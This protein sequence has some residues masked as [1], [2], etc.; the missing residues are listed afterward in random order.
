MAF[1]LHY[2][3]VTV[4]DRIPETS[5]YHGNHSHL[6]DENPVIPNAAQAMMNRAVPERPRTITSPSGTSRTRPTT[7]APVTPWATL[8]SAKAANRFDH[9]PPEVTD[10]VQLPVLWNTQKSA[11]LMTV[12]TNASLAQ[13]PRRTVPEFRPQFRRRGNRNSLGVCHL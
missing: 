11:S 12:V 3:L 8:S 6:Q 7:R 4:S 5:G 13:L 1:F 2:Y 9:H 10:P